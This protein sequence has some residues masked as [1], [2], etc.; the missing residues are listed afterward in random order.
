MAGTKSTRLCG[1]YVIY[2]VETEQCYVGRSSDI[3]TRWSTHR[4]HLLRGIHQ[5][6]LLQTV[7][8]REGL[9]VLRMW[10]IYLCSQAESVR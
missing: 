2:H 8:D 3:E 7:V 10:P 9:Q 1:V 4:Y 6:R 5:S